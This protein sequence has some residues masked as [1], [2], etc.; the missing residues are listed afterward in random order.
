MLTLTIG[1]DASNSIVLNESKVSRQHARLLILD[2]G[3][4]QLQD[5]NSRNGTYV[6]GNRINEVYLNPGDVVKCGDAFLNWSQFTGGAA[7]PPEYANNIGEPE[8]AGQPELPAQEQASLGTVFNY[9]SAKVFSFDD[10]LKKDWNM[11]TPIL[12]LCICPWVVC[13]IVALYYY[14]NF[15]FDFVRQ[16]ML[17]MVA[18]VFVFGATQLLT[19]IILS[20]KKN[21][22]LMQKV[23]VASVYSFL[24]FAMVFVVFIVRSIRS[25][26]RYSENAVLLHSF[27]SLLQ[28][29]ALACIAFT[30]IIFLYRF[31]RGIS[32]SK[33]KSAYLTIIA[34]TLNLFL[35]V[36]FIHLLLTSRIAN[37]L[38]N[39]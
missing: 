21:L 20:A 33:E 37:N 39:F 36:F 35:Q 31:F 1:R 28:T 7:P 4:V 13:L 34:I 3:R 25:E 17:P 23:F 9:L 6:N 26:I 30:L 22:Q 12:F 2:D 15:Q 27:F 10:L 8:T 24:I 5:L 19:I 29:T 11:L 38:I 32:M 14:A 16:V 18:A